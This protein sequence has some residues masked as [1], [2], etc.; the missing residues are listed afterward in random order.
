MTRRILLHIGS[1]K[2][3]STYLQQVLLQNRDLLLT[4]HVRYPHDGAGHPGNAAALA[5]VDQG[6]LDQWFADGVNT[7]ILS[8]EDLYSLA[9]RG[10]ALAALAR[11][12]GIAV[13]LITFLRP[14]SEFI[15]GDYSQFMKQFFDKFLAERK[16]YDGRDFETFAQRRI[17]TMKPALYLRQWQQRFPDLPL[18]LKGHRDIRATM[19]GLLG[20]HLGEAL[21]W[22]VSGDRVNP[23][24]RMVDCDAIVAAMYDPDMPDDDITQMFKDAFHKVGTDDPGKT[25]ART[26]WL[27]AQFA[28][29]NADLLKG[30]SFDNRRKTDSV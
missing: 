8:H 21:D 26:E 11:E 13:Q 28:P 10:D 3:G 12:N 30:F 25:N 7:V 9:K 16:P 23:S 24:L 2:C 29:Q 5:D 15:Y 6:M 14:F 18:I 22:T 20:A 4:H 19:T 17:N 27:E 1:P